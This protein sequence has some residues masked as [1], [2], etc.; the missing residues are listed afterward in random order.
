[1]PTRAGPFCL[2]SKPNFRRDNHVE[3]KVV[4]FDR[5]SIKQLSAVLRRIGKF[6]GAICNFG[7][8]KKGF[9]ISVKMS[10]VAIDRFMPGP[11]CNRHSIEMAAL[12]LSCSKAWSISNLGQMF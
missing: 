3:D 9:S 6:M 1:M 10:G 8:L 7:D 4:C 2:A 12:Y 5:E 11:A